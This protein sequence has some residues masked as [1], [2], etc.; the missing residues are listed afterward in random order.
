MLGLKNKK[1]KK[2]GAVIILYFLDLPGVGLLGSAVL[3][4]CSDERI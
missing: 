4:R 1:S 3:L 2:A